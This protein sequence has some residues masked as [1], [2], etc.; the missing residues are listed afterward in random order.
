MQDEDDVY[1]G[2][3]AAPIASPEM[4]E[5][6]RALLEGLGEDPGRDGLRATPERVARSLAF[7]TSGYRID[8]K[9]VVGTALFEAEYDEMVVLPDIEVYSLCEHHLL[10]FFGR[11]HIAY[12]PENK[13]VGLSKLARLAEVYARRLQVQERLTTEIANAINDILEPKGVGV[14]IEAQH[15]CMM[16]R[17]VEKQRSRAVTSCMLGRFRTD[18]RT[19]SEFL[20]LIGKTTD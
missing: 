17:G 2:E 12:L 4:I 7:L 14:V 8:P 18:A 13:I 1:R 11:C 6:V 5:V 3:V 10:P 16:M 15:L 20:S 9:A 19:R